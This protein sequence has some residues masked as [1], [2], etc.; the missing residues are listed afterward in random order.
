MES[1]AAFLVDEVLPKEPIRHWVL[2]FPHEL[3]FLL[4]QH[5]AMMGK[6]LERL[7]CY[8]S[9]PAVSE[10]RLTLTGNASSGF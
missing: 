6:G 1:S 8:I 7:C 9:P 10:K 5:P 4:A 2:S 3:R